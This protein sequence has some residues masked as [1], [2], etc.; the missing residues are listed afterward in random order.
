MARAEVQKLIDRMAAP[1]IAAPMF[2]VS[3]PALTLACCAE[4]VMGSFP[5]HGTRSREE[6]QGWLDEMQDGIKRLEDR[7]LKPAP[8]AV[9]LVVHASNPRYPGDLELVEKY[10]VPVVLTSKGAPGDA[11]KRIHG[12]GAVALHDIANHRHA[13]KA[14]EAGVDGVIAV[15][16]GAGGHTGTINPF[17]LMNEV[18]Q[19]GD[20]FAIILAGSITTGRDVL[21][22]QAMGADLAYIGTR[23]IAT[24]EAMAAAAHKQMILDTRATDVFLT[25]SIDGAPANWLTP[26]LL[27]AGIDLDVLRTTPPSKI[28]SSQEN[29]KRWK[30]IYTAGHGVGNIGD[31]PAAAELCRRLIAQY[32]EAKGA[33]ARIAA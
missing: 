19:L 8:W 17:A 22:A 9:N 26:S 12:W 13:E 16:G 4:G 23:F 5:A 3:N 31:V 15:A 6:F 30:D 18:R 21:A 32:K 25:S 29:K 11:I 7:G 14:L 24:R 10:K 27:A 28:V 1:I 2:L 33:V 20:H